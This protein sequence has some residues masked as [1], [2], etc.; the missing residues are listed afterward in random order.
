VVIDLRR[1]SPTYLHWHAEELSADSFRMLYIPNGCAH[2]FQTLK[3]NCIVFYQMGEY[4]HPE[5]A[6]GIRCNDPALGIV[7]PFPARIISEKDK[8]YEDLKL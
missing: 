6:Q 3:D 1:D 8:M 2:G 7:W 5:C 4:Y